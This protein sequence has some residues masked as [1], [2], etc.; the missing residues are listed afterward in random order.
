MSRRRHRPLLPLH[1]AVVGEFVLTG[2][3]RPDGNRVNHEVGICLPQ[4]TINVTS[5]CTL[6]LK[7]KYSTSAFI[8]L[9]VTGKDSEGRSNVPLATAG[10]KAISGAVNDQVGYYYLDPKRCPQTYTSKIKGAKLLGSGGLTA[11]GMK[12]RQQWDRC[13]RESYKAVQ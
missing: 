13:T 4:F 6:T 3:S 8:S 1:H 12:G 2:L 11:A 7:P 5:K 10:A 9:L